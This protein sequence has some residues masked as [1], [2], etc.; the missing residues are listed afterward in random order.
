L[1][2]F[3]VQEKGVNDNSTEPLPPH[4]RIN[5]DPGKA[6]IRVIEPLFQRSPDTHKSPIGK[7][8]A[9]NRRRRTK[10]CALRLL[11]KLVSVKRTPLWV[12][13]EQ[14]SGAIQLINVQR[15]RGAIRDIHRALLIAMTFF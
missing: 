10:H 11:P 4:L 9:T 15:S 14:L 2:T 13:N 12:T 1:F 5:K 6:P 7:K 3:Y 8:G